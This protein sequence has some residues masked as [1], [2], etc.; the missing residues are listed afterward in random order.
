MANPLYDNLISKHSDNDACFLNQT[1]REI[2]S[3]REFS[4]LTCQ[5]ANLLTKY[6][7]QPGDRVAVQAAKTFEMVVLYGA[8]IQAG[9]VFLSLNTD[10]KK[11]EVSYFLEDSKPKVFICDPEKLQNF[12]DIITQTGPKVLTLDKFGKGSLTSEA[13]MMSKIF[14]TVHRN[15]DDLA[16]L[17]YTSGTTGRSKGAMLTQNNLL[18]NAKTLTDLW[19]VSENDVLIHALPIFHTHG[20]FVALNTALLSGCQVNFLFKFD[21]DEVIRAM[22]SSTLLMGVPTFYTRL[23][24]DRRL[25]ANQTQKMRLFISGSA[26]LLA[27]THEE[28]SLRTGHHILERYGMTETSMITSNPCN[29]ER[30]PGTVGTPLT[31][32]EIKIT[33]PETGKE[34]AVG[35]IGVI[36]VR[37]PNVFKGYWNMP[38]K[39][40]LELKKDGFFITGDLGKFNADGYL[41]IVGREKDL[42]IS[43]GYNVYPKEVEDVLNEIDQIDET[44]VFGVPDNDFGERVVAAIVMT[45]IEEFSQ[46]KAEIFVNTKLA[47]YKQPKEYI[48]MQTLPRNTMGKVQK[49]QLRYMFQPQ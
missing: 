40:A 20:L 4:I 32:V 8:T 5:Y 49:N 17:L 6:G 25:T 44:A 37:G 45:G 18:S 2:I 12:T 21:I 11:D 35:E 39:T 30:K 26:P 14:K 9:G 38:D 47:R 10:Y 33:D 28:F 27:E 46:N 36:E 31:D 16:A 24:A 34:K 3:Y 1:G 41:S 48:V 29:G 13:G 15:S 22:H 7:L 23:L 19:E 42:I 43:G